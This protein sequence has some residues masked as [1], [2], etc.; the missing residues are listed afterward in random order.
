[1]IILIA[2]TSFL[3]IAC[4]IPVYIDLNGLSLTSD[5]TEHSIK[6]E[7]TD[8]SLEMVK[9]GP[10]LVLLY[11]TDSSAVS[12]YSSVCE[13]FNK[14]YNSKDAAKSSTPLSYDSITGKVGS[15]EGVELY[16]FKK[17]VDKKFEAPFAYC[18]DLNTYIGQKITIST[19]GTDLCLENTSGSTLVWPLTEPNKTIYLFAAFTAQGT[20][21]NTFSNVYWSELCYVG[22][23][24]N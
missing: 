20:I 7:G 17:S 1:M 4:G 12:K 22:A 21:E 11:A 8:P 15:F 16:A 23:L 2:A 5:I 9:N 18:L 3:F 24:E 13:A 19:S 10:G 14:K 6:V